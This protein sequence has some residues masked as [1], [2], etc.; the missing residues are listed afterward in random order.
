MFDWKARLRNKTFWLFI[1]GVTYKIL[2]DQGLVVP[3]EQ[4]QYY[5]DALCYTLMYLG[6]FVDT[7]TPGFG[8][9]NK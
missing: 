8:D 1:A 3:P 2:Q 7:S 4:W 5:V 9:K 6:I